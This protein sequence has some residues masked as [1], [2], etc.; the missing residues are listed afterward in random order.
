ML[1]LGLPEVVY[2]DQ[3]PINLLPMYGA[4][5]VIKTADQKKADEEFI[6][7]VTTN[8]VSRDS[9]AVGF[10]AIGMKALGDGD[11]DTAMKRFNQSWLLDP[12]CFLAYWG[13][14]KVTYNFVNPQES[15]DFFDKSLALLQSNK[16]RPSLKDVKQGLYYD[17][18]RAY[19]FAALLDSLKA[20]VYTKKADGFYEKL[21]HENPKFADGY[22]LWL[23]NSMIS[24]NYRRAW[25]IV[26]AARRAGVN[27]ISKETI[28]KLSEKMPEPNE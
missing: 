26:H 27:D 10:W 11:K 18:G 28:K 7:K 1:T 5:S 23:M 21:S 2:A 8:G 4:P 12:E 16:E 14:G 19:S 25:D 13:F 15:L 22:H 24:K 6:S 9:A 17:T 3:I 20:P